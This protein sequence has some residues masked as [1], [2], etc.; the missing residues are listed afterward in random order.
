MKFTEKTI[1]KLAELGFKQSKTQGLFFY[2]DPKTGLSEPL[3]IWC[4]R[5]SYFFDPEISFTVSRCAGIGDHTLRYTAKK[6]LNVSE[7]AERIIKENGKDDQ[8]VDKAA[9]E[10]K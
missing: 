9:G 8:A 3:V 10:T 6:L 7:K 5:K 2:T 4:Y 1:K